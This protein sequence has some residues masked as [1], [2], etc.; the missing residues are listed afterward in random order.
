MNIVDMQLYN[1]EFVYLTD[2]AVLSNAWAGTLYLKYNLANAKCLAGGSNFDFLIGSDN[3]F[4]YI[5]K[6]GKLWESDLT[7]ELVDIVFDADYNGFWILT[8][9][10]L[11]FFDTSAK[12]MEQK[13]EGE[14]FTAFSL[15][16]NGSKL[17]IATSDG[18]SIFD[19]GLNK[20]T[21]TNKKLPC[22]KLTTVAEI[23]GSL[24]FGSEKGAFM[25]KNVG[26]FNYYASRRWLADDKV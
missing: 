9:T 15:M 14:N 20:I 12:K 11:Y 7:A 8:T 10:G 18:Y 2:K 19:K 4:Q 3:G 1:N 22:N 17:V 25:L 6:A 13:T 21:S 16:K 24:W 23:N 5:S 26:G